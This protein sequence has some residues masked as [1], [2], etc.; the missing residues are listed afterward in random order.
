MR[1]NACNMP[2]TSAI[3]TRPFAVRSAVRVAIMASPGRSLHE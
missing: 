1:R 2:S 3:S